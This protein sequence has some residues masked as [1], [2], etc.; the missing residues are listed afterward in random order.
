M[1]MEDVEYQKN[2]L[3]S[4]IL[5]REHKL[6]ELD[7]IGVKIADGRATTEEYSDVI[8]EKAKWADEIN[9]ARARIKE[10]ES[11]EPESIEPESIEPIQ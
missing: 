8:A 4:L 6:K 2:L 11:I 1:T 10:L 3:Y 9:Q 5:N 7:Y